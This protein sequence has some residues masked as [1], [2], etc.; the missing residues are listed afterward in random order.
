VIVLELW[1]YVNEM[2]RRLRGDASGRAVTLPEGQYLAVPGVLVDEDY[3]H[4]TLTADKKLRVDDPTTQAAVQ[5]VEDK[6][7]IVQAD[8]DD[9]D[10]Y[11]AN[12]AAL[13][14]EATV[15]AVN[16]ALGVHDTDIKT[17]IAALQ[18]D[19]DNPAQYKAD[20]SGLE[21]E[22]DASTRYTALAAYVD[23]IE[24]YIKHATYGLNALH[25]LIDAVEGKLDVPANFMADV[26]GLALEA[27]LT[28]IKGA[29]W[30]TE[31]LKAIYDFIEINHTLLGT[32]ASEAE[33][34]EVKLDTPATFKA[35]V[36]GLATAAKLE[37]AMQK[38]TGPAYNQDTDSLEA[39]REA[40]DAVPGG[41]T[42]Q[43]VWEYATRVLTNLSDVRAAKIDNLDATVSSRLAAA[44]YTAERGTNSAA[45]ASA[46]TAALATVLGYYTQAKAGYLDA[47]ISG[48][49]RKAAKW[50]A[51]VVLDTVNPATNQWYTL[52]D[53]TTDVV[54]DYI[55]MRDN[56]S[57]LAEVRITIDGEV[58]TKTDLVDLAINTMV[59]VYITPTMS[60]L[61]G[62]AEMSTDESIRMVMDRYPLSGQSVK[63]EYRDTEGAGSHFVGMVIY[64]REE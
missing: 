16:T 59:F 15:D 38:A 56:V 57:H 8:L 32:V 6:I 3:H 20:V 24:T 19:L 54:I 55:T 48:A 62:V 43:Q 9:P 31:T 29:G 33:A 50:K 37:D 17:V 25:L 61:T 41:A 28:A 30:T 14:L 60:L 5:A 53:T 63:I 11:K 26:S 21:T 4:L 34:I 13:A 12:V 52:F 58:I 46:W 49:T 45:L 42:A 47:A 18:T 7:D 2:F 51:P 39:L 23:E 36:S 40:I 10:Q 22:A 44:A 1:D 27:T 35:D 64:H